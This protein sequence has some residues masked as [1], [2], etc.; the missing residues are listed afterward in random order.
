MGEGREWV[1]LHDCEAVQY[2]QDG[3]LS[4]FYAISEPQHSLIG[5]LYAAIAAKEGRC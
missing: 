5:A 3:T 2:P 1:N 4:K